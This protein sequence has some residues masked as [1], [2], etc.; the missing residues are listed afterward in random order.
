MPQYPQKA[1]TLGQLIIQGLEDPP[2]PNDT[3]RG[4]ADRP[5]RKLSPNFDALYDDL[6]LGMDPQNIVYPPSLTSDGASP[7]VQRSPGAAALSS[8]STLLNLASFPGGAPAA[9]PDAGK[10]QQPG[11]KHQP[12]ETGSAIA[13]ETTPTAQHSVALAAP[14]SPQYSATFPMSPRGGPTTREDQQANVMEEEAV[15]STAAIEGEMALAAA[16]PSAIVIEEPVG[17]QLTTLSSRVMSSPAE[18]PAAEVTTPTRMP[19]A[20]YF[21]TCMNSSANIGETRRGTGGG[22]GGGV[23][24]ERSAS[25]FNASG[26]AFVTPTDSDVSFVKMPSASCST[27]GENATSVPVE[28]VSDSATGTASTGTGSDTL[29]YRGGGGKEQAVVRGVKDLSAPRVDRS[30]VPEIP[31]AETLT[32]QAATGAAGLADEDAEAVQDETAGPEVTATK[33]TLREGEHLS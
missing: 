17:G 22:G 13:T 32:N 9:L 14:A 26:A 15:Q 7:T 31:S 3:S 21:G 27:I 28:T 29:P 24:L 20:D 8:P 11:S 1:L 30:E 4:G 19:K 2:A 12:G 10:A 5:S 33:E 6:T 18:K 23:G 25:V 16:K